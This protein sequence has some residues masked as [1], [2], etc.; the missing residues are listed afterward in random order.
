ML[1]FSFK[2]IKTL[3]SV[4]E[5]YQEWSTH[6]S[7]QLKLKST[8]MSTCFPSIIDEKDAFNYNT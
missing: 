6:E 7:F 1:Y 2:P 8:V 5:N 4:L 3:E